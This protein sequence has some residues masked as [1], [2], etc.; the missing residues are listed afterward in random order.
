ME[1]KR[2]ILLIREN[3]EEKITNKHCLLTGFKVEFLLI[4]F[5]IEFCKK[6]QKKSPEK[7]Y[8]FDEHVKN[9]EIGG[10]PLRP[11]KKRTD[12]LLI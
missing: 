10:P 12:I 7:L 6:N 3:F 8:L 2:Q 11:W 1:I 9:P 4:F 5:S